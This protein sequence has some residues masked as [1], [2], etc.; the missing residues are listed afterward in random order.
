MRPQQQTHTKAD[1][2]GRRDFFRIA[3]K[4]VATAGALLA[5]ASPDAA[6]AS[7][8][9]KSKTAKIASNTYAVRH[10]FKRMSRYRS[11]SEKIQ[12]LQA[13]YGTI[14][15]LDFPQFTKD[16]Y[17][18]VMKMDLWS[19]LFGDTEDDSQ[20]G[21]RVWRGKKRR[22]D[23]DP[24]RPSSKRWLDKLATNIAKT[25]V[26]ATHISNNAPRNIC[27]ADE[28]KRREGIRVAKAWLDAAKQIGVLSM[29]VNSGGPRIVPGAEVVGRGYPKNDAI[30]PYLRH[31]IES[32]RELAEYGEKVGVKVTI[33]NHWGLTA[34]PMNVRIILEEVDHPYLEASPDFCNW[35]HEYMLYHGLKALIPYAKSMCHAKRWTRYPNVDIARCVGILK[36]A[37]YPGYIALEYE[38]GPDD[39]VQGT[40]KL[41][42]DVVAAL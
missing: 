2:S 25:G 5:V 39:P 28:A 14:T 21:E 16:T 12:K 7:S 37:N 10:L 36:E 13:R 27:V 19:S 29:R 35:E 42:R 17:P 40:L 3:G 38:S 26:T 22:G 31:A 24:S 33:E 1:G 30:L 8:A 32:F 23:F 41:M 15:M 9:E 18:G 34:H 20:F 11:Q 4:G 6:G